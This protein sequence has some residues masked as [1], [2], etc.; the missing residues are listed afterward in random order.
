MRGL[1]HGILRYWHGREAKRNVFPRFECMTSSPSTPEKGL[2][3]LTVADVLVTT[4]EEKVG[5]WLWCYTN[6]TLY[7]AVKNVC[8]YNFDRQILKLFTPM[9]SI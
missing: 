6:D 9:T 8:F 4:G 5:S 1:V 3:N 7:D 2:E